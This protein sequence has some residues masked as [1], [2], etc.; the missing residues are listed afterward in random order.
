MQENEQQQINNENKEFDNK[1]GKRHKLVL[2]CLIFFTVFIC[3]CWAF[4]FKRIINKPLRYEEKEIA[5][6]SASVCSGPNCDKISDIDL[7]AKDTDNDGLNDYDELNIYNTSPYL[8]DSDSDGFSDKD[9]IDSENDP[10]C[11]IGRDCSF[12]EVISN[13]L[14]NDDILEK[15]D[16]GDKLFD[17]LQNQISNIKNGDISALEQINDQDQSQLQNVLDGKAS[18]AFLRQMLVQAGMDNNL[19]S[20]ISD[21]DLMNSYSEMLGKEN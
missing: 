5:K 14:G 10:N 21:E 6:E 17:N 11:P 19:L 1:L 2:I 12:P 9:E 7:S 13:E 18:V 15:N 4:Q 20:Q 8:E 3:F 16:Q